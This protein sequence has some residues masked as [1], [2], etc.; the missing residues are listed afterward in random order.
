MSK[1]Q[2]LMSGQAQDPDPPAEEAQDPGSSAPPAAVPKPAVDY[3][4]GLVA[5]APA[6]ILALAASVLVLVGQFTPMYESVEF[7]RIAKN[8]FLQQDVGWALAAGAGALALVGLF[9][10]RNAQVSGWVALVVG[11]LTV[12]LAAF[13]GLSEDA[14]TLTSVFTEAG[15]RLGRGREEVAVADSG[16]YLTAIGGLAAI[17]A[18]VSMLWIVAGRKS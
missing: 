10:S 11:V 12:G 14:R 13:Y 5:F 16:I 6:G 3:S 18:G 15:D 2:E 4:V 9:G 8:T 17:A 7:L 1:F